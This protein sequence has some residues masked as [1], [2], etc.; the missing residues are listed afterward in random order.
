MAAKPKVTKKQLQ[1]DQE[2]T[3]QTKIEELS[4]EYR[5]IIDGAAEIGWSFPEAEDSFISRGLARW[6]RSQPKFLSGRYQDQDKI[7]AEYQMHFLRYL[8]ECCPEILEDLRPLNQYFH[9]IFNANRERFN[10]LYDGIKIE[11]L[12][13]LQSSIETAINHFLPFYP[14]LRFESPITRFRTF[15]YDFRWGEN[16]GTLLFLRLFLVPFESDE[17]RSKAISD[18]ITYVE[19]RIV[20][21]VQRDLLGS[22]VTE[23]MVSIFISGQ[24]R[25]VVR[26]VMEDA[27]EAYFARS[28]RSHLIQFLREFSRDDDEV[29][30]AFIELQIG[31]LAWATKHN[32]E[33][34][35]MLRYGHYFLSKFDEN[36]EIGVAEIQIPQLSTYSLVAIPF[37]FK[38]NS[39]FPGFEDKEDYE[40]RLRN[41]IELELDQHFQYTANSLDVDK[42]KKETSPRKY[43]RVKWLVRWT[44]QGWSIDEILDE[45]IGSGDEIPEQEPDES[46]IRR[47]ITQF[48]KYDL[49]I[50]QCPAMSFAKRAKDKSV[51]A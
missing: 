51:T 32:L 11:F 30:A 37:E 12:Y 5:D 47:A 18:A 31:L 1:L 4:A 50:K 23:E 48:A 3:R 34:D 41:Q 9:T 14:H 13:D 36:P 44:V 21:D 42:H 40:G 6:E 28:G 19:N 15:K 8:Q 20:L 26:S 45:I 25:N 27:E 33:K 46:T 7:R 24:A 43:E 29:V 35:W 10:I 39:W 22:D 17:H 49:P 16:L 38:F 2:K